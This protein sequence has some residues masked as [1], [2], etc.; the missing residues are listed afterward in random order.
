MTIAV[1]CLAFA[2]MTSATSKA[3]RVTASN[4]PA[5]QVH[6]YAWEE[7]GLIAPMYNEY[8]NVAKG[9]SFIAQLG[10]PLTTVEALV[11]LGPSKPVANHPPLKV[12]IYTSSDGI[13]ITRL[14]TV[15]RMASDFEGFLVTG[16][17]R[18]VFD[19]ANRQVK[20][21][22]GNEYMIAFETPYGIAGS[23]GGDSAHLIGYPQEFL[24]L[25]ASQA[26]DGVHWEEFSDH[27]E[28]GIVARVVPEPA[29]WTY[30]AIAFGLAIGIGRRIRADE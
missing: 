10:G 3:E 6:T 24:G 18:K 29:T 14:A 20:L 4:L 1:H 19:F 9:Q 21:T 26:P 27:R 12:S 8:N 28:L 15:E 5:H 17:S 25:N 23:H 16:F 11:T 22:A 7:V 2:L 30:C 13:P